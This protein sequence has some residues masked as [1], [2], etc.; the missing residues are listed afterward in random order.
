MSK[1]IVVYN[2]LDLQCGDVIRAVYSIRDVSED[3]YGVVTEID[4]RHVKIRVITSN[5]S[6]DKDTFALNINAT[7][8]LNRI[9]YII[10]RPNCKLK[11]ENFTDTL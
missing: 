6:Y 10:D 11:Q 5:S 1:D 2:L 4:R 8:Y 3:L 7:L 9:V